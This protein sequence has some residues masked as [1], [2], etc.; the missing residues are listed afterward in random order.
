MKE[1]TN[2]EQTIDNKIKAKKDVKKVVILN[3]MF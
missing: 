1:I 2:L 3:N